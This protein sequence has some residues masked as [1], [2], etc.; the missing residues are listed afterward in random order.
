M[1][2]IL[3]DQTIADREPGHHF[4]PSIVPCG[5]FYGEG[6]RLLQIADSRRGKGNEMNCTDDE[7]VA[8]IE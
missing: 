7:Q 5:D 4:V 3:W 6:S 2:A 8:R 1:S